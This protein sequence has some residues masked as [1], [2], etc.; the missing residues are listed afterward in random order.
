MTAWTGRAD[1]GPGRVR[2]RRKKAGVCVCMYVC[3]CA[4]K[5]SSQMCKYGGGGDEN[6]R[7]FKGRRIARR[8]RR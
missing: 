4:K 5:K 6:A 2:K 3:V 1:R 8:R 7:N